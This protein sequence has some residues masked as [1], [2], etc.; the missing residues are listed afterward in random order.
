MHT[1]ANLMTVLA[2][3]GMLSA[4]GFAAQA[5]DTH[6]TKAVPNA[7]AKTLAVKPQT[8]SAKLKEVTLTGSVNRQE[9]RIAGTLR[10][11]FTL[12]TSAGEKVHLPAA[13]TG[14]TDPAI[15]LADYVGQSVR[16]VAMAREQ[17]KGDKTIVKVRTIKSIE[18]IAAATPANSS[19]RAA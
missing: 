13:K 7:A 15:Q 1:Y 19:H 3:T 8:G 16:L 4:Q 9:M 5:A 6:A 2:V 18:K 11:V 12:V 17:K 14:K 10:A